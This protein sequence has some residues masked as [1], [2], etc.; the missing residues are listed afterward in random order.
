MFRILILFHIYDVVIEWNYENVRKAV[1][2]WYVSSS[3]G[4]RK[5]FSTVMGLVIGTKWF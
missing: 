1:A 3:M 5:A 2:K 4:N